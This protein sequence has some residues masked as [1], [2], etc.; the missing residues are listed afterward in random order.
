[1]D[2]KE[3][4]D[5]L[6]AEVDILKRISKFDD[7]KDRIYIRLMNP[8]INRKTIDQLESVP[9]L[10]LTVTFVLDMRCSEGSGSE[11]QYNERAGNKKRDARP[12][13]SLRKKTHYCWA[14]SYPCFLLFP[15]CLSKF[16]WFFPR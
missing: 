2:Y 5:K 7:I 15:C 11:R 13:A 16:S 3:Y 6:Q 10:D 8:L 9:F 4:I 14:I 1:M 12:S